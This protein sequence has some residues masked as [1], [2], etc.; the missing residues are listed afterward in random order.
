MGVF[1]RGKAIKIKTPSPILR[2]GLSYGSIGNKVEVY[3][4]TVLAE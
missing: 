3:I 2:E 4:K 1:T